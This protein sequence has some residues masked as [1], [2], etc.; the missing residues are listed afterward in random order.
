MVGIAGSGKSTYTKNNFT[1]YACVSLDL[2]KK[3]LPNYK[4]SQLIKRYQNEMPFAPKHITSDMPANPAEEKDNECLSKDQS[5]NNRKAEYI[6]IIDFLKDGKDVVV[7]D[8]N[9]TPEIRWPYITLALQY[10][11]TVKAVYFSDTRVAREQN[12]K[13]KG[14]DNVPQ[15]AIM[16]QQAMMERPKLKEGFDTIITAN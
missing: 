1:N 8:T 9:L 11:A 12:A 10:C 15:G 7:D 2:N 5:S 4:K 16:K 6:Q 3:D 13:R 14:S